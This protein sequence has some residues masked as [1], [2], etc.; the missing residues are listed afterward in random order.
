MLCGRRSAHC[1]AHALPTAPH[2]QAATVKKLQQ[3]EGNSESHDD[4][5]VPRQHYG[6]RAVS[7]SDRDRI[8]AAA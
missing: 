5:P 6:V 8:V 1:Q 4:Q 3:Q 2:D 7:A